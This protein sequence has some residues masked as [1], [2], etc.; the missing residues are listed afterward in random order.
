M[1]ELDKTKTYYLGN[2]S[3]EQAKQFCEASGYDDKEHFL[4]SYKDG[5]GMD[6]ICWNGEFWDWN[7]DSESSI[8]ALTLFEPETLKV[9]D[10]V[11]ICG[12]EG[13]VKVCHSTCRYYIHINGNWNSKW[14]RILKLDA[15][16]FSEEILGYSKS[17]VFPECDTLE[18]ITKL[19]NALKEEEKR[20]QIA[21]VPEDLSKTPMTPD[22]CIKSDPVNK[23]AHYQLKSGIQVIDIIEGAGLGFH[24]ANVVK[25]ILRAGKKDPSKELE[26]LKKAEYYLH[27]KIKQLTEEGTFME[28]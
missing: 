8:D 10:K 13:E 6:S 12:I 11:T 2:L 24:L 20:Q 27:R 26:D 5:D 9:G 16:E 22:E 28:G 19:V 7:N 23:P 14:F 1:K 18:D 3:R 17:G 21:N 15:G 4:R 25:Y